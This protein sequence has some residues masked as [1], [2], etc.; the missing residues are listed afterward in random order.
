LSSFPF[1]GHRFRRAPRG[2]GADFVG[3]IALL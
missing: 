3:E 1:I 2:T